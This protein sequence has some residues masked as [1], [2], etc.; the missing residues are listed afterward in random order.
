MV[1]FFERTGVC[2]R[3]SA[4]VAALNH[5]NPWKIS[6]PFSDLAATSF[7]PVILGLVPN[8]FFRTGFIFFASLNAPLPRIAFRYI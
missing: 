5:T 3:V 8:V 2:S 1:K 7:Q 6:T 4:F